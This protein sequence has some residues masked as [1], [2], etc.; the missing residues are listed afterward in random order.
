MYQD[1]MAPATQD[2]HNDNIS[3]P[4]KTQ[5][6]HEEFNTV[7]LF[8]Y[9]SCSYCCLVSLRYKINNKYVYILKCNNFHVQVRLMWN[10]WWPLDNRNIIQSWHQ[11]LASIIQWYI[12][13]TGTEN[14][15]VT[16]EYILHKLI[17]QLLICK[18]GSLFNTI[19]VN[20]II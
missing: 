17:L 9:F 12:E 18:S 13:A 6:F 14:S 3:P 10:C 19:S 20:Q 11:Q 7:L 2:T 5:Y 4:N 1:A 8:Y 15:C 16:S